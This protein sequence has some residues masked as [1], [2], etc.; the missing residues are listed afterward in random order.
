MVIPY[1]RL[2]VFPHVLSDQAFPVSQLLR[3]SA[4]CASSDR[5]RAAGEAGADQ[6]LPSATV[7]I[8]QSCKLLALL[9]V[10]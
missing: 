2:Y 3:S 10:P 5:A 4:L 7:D 8:I 1:I 6:L 9:C